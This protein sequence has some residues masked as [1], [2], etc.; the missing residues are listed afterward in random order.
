M[1]NKKTERDE[2][3]IQGSIFVDWLSRPRAITSALARVMPRPGQ[4]RDGYRTLYASQILFYFYYLIHLTDYM[5]QNNT[6]IE[7]EVVESTSVIGAH[8]KGCAHAYAPRLC[9]LNTITSRQVTHSFVLPSIVCA[10]V[11]LSMGPFVHLKQ[12]IEPK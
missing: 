1:W 9:R 12:L 7:K 2:R 5:A 6:K 11:C 3:C 10:Y 8:D 4:T